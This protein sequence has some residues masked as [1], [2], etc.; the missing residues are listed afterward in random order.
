M[1]T[2]MTQRFW[3]RHAG[4]ERDT[5]LERI[6]KK[7]STHAEQQ[8]TTNAGANRTLV[9]PRRTQLARPHGT[10]FESGNVNLVSSAAFPLD[11][12]HSPPDR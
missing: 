5:H 11:T 7:T 1:S 3:R 6:R 10:T 2:G 12:D 8:H 4:Q 9:F